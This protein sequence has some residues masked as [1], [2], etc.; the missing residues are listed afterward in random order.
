M[1][2]VNQR[3]PS[4]PGVMSSR[5]WVALETEKVEI[6]PSRV[7]RPMIVGASLLVYQSAPTEP[8]WSPSAKASRAV[9]QVEP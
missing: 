3:L 8:D 2:L 4:G 5:G 9:D 1:L 7:T 6:W